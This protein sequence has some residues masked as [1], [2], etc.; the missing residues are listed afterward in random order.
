MTVCVAVRCVT[1]DMCE[2]QFRAHLV[3]FLVERNS[4]EDEVEQ[5]MRLRF[6]HI[7][8]GKLSCHFSSGEGEAWQEEVVRAALL[9]ILDGSSGYK[10]EVVHGSI[11]A[12]L[13]PI[14]QQRNRSMPI[15][16]GDALSDKMRHLRIVFHKV[17]WPGRTKEVNDAIQEMQKSTDETFKMFTACGTGIRLLKHVKAGVDAQH[18]L[19]MAQDRVKSLAGNADS[20]ILCLAELDTAAAA[21]D[22]HVDEAVLSAFGLA[23]GDRVGEIANG[24]LPYHRGSTGQPMHR[25]GCDAWR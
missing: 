15:T 4:G 11:Y 5:Q 24:G 8:L 21:L 16:M 20:S 23:L 14:P 12:F 3:P 18:Q 25:F 6:A 13:S 9:S 17:A 10:I 7:C 19:E 1:L 2:V 22:F